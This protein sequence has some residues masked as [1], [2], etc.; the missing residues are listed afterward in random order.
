MDELWA[1][2]FALYIQIFGL[3]RRRYDADTGTRIRNKCRYHLS[4]EVSLP[5]V[6][7]QNNL[8]VASKL[9]REKLPYLPIQIEIQ[10]HRLMFGAYSISECIIWSWKSQQ[11][12]SYLLFLVVEASC[13]FKDSCIVFNYIYNIMSEL[14]PPTSPPALFKLQRQPAVWVYLK[15]LLD[16]VKTWS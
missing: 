8:G 13:L 10:L 2:F 7:L 12:H 3:L 6:L 5:L 4:C 1:P 11:N 16:Q 14:T 15:I 9:Y